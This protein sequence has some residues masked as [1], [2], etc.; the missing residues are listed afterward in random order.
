ME[1]YLGFAALV[2]GFLDALTTHLGLRDG[3]AEESN[4]VWRYLYP[5]V[6]VFVFFCLCT[7][8]PVALSTVALWLGGVG[9]QAGVVA[10][11]FCA[12]IWNASVLYR[13]WKK[14]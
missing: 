11:A 6:P 5:R 13:A 14:R 3:S 10:V 9:G 8:V 12:P 7:F 2:A 4:A 1:L